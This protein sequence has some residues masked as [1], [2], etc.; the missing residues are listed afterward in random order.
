ME[1]IEKKKRVKKIKEEEEIS[2]SD[3]EQEEEIFEKE[4]IE[5][6]NYDKIDSAPLAPKSKTGYPIV[7][8]TKT[9]IIYRIGENSN[10][11]ISKELGEKS[12]IGDKIYL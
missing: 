1:D 2:I 7:M 6:F 10:S 11:S 9:V 4:N 12:I 8:I 5:T 3:I